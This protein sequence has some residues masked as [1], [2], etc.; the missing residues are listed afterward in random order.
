MR[1]TGK[2]LP[3]EGW[4]FESIN[5]GRARPD[6]L[7]V[8]AQR[9]CFTRTIEGTDAHLAVWFPR[10]FGEKTDDFGLSLTAS[11]DGSAYC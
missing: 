11:H 8:G 5:A 4:R 1:T 7:P 6:S 9:L 3:A 10:E 2:A